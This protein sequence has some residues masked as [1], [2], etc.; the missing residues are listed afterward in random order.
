M[1]L[2]DIIGLT[3]KTKDVLH[4]ME[5]IGLIS[6]STLGRKRVVEL[7]Q[8]GEEMAAHMKAILDLLDNNTESHAG[9]LG[10]VD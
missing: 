8:K 1:D 5:I 10:F 9:N 7:T 6:V 4:E 3:G 2:Y